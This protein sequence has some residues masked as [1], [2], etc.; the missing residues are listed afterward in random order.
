MTQEIEILDNETTALVAIEQLSPVD[1]FKP[2]GCQPL[3]DKV[4]QMVEEFQADVTTPKGRAAMKS[5]ALKVAKSKTLIDEKGKELVSVLKLQTTAIDAERK[6]VRDEF[7]ALRDKVKAPAV[8]W[9]NTEKERVEKLTYALNMIKNYAKAA[10]VNNSEHIKN[11]LFDAKDIFEKTMWQ[12]FLTV[13]T[14]AYDETSAI[15]E[16]ALNELEEQ[17]KKDLE[18]ERL[19]AEEVAREQA[20]RDAR[21]AAQA[22]EAARLAAEEEAARQLALAKQKAEAEKL[23]AETAAAAAQQAIID[24]AN[25]EKAKMQA[26]A[27]A[28]IAAEKAKAEALAKEQAQI[29]AA[30]QA[31]I[32]AQAARDADKA[33]KAKINNAIVAAIVAAVPSLSADNAKNIVAAILQGQVPNTTI[34]Y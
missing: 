17:R 25:A 12:E 2:Q 9:E 24:A 1:I 16:Q 28:A 14:Q 21:I 10:V 15:L 26:A 27:D 30:K 23:A 31:E 34:K 32:D 4:R 18:L 11:S 13:A 22:A 20:A 6:R 8:E 33:H 5:M 3:I 7:D 19:R 29:A